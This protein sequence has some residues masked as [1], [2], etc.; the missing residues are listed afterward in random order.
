MKPQTKVFFRRFALRWL[1]KLVD[2]ADDRLHV[3][4]VRFREEIENQK[5]APRVAQLS[6]RMPQAGPKMA[7]PMKAS[8]APEPKEL[9]VAQT[10]QRPSSETFAEW[11]MRKSGV[12]P[13]SKK[14]AR[15]HRER[16]TAAA[17]DLRFAR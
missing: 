6:A 5:M 7:W 12:A 9:A 17:F 14:A 2:L 13:R 8:I 4:E 16:L 11:E 10:S 1:R 15:K 3:A